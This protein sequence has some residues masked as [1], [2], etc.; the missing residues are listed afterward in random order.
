MNAVLEHS[1]ITRN[2]CFQIDN[3]GSKLE[4]DIGISQITE[5]SIVNWA[6]I[7]C[8]FLIFAHMFDRGTQQ[9]RNL[10]RNFLAAY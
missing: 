3:T 6:I 1:G 5:S 10:P 9:R 8:T 4:E 7:M 2:R